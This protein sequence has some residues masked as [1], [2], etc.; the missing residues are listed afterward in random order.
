[1]T[2]N[3]DVDP[4][5]GTDFSP[6]RL[7]E[8]EQLRAEIWKLAATAEAA[9]D[10]TGL[11]QNLLNQTGPVLGCE[12]ISF[13][14]RA[15]TQTEFM[16]KLQWRADGQNTGLG[17][18]VPAS[19]F[20]QSLGQPYRQLLFDKGLVSANPVLERFEKEYGPRSVLIVPYGTPQQPEGYITVN[21]FTCAKEYSP[22]EIDLFIELSKIIHL[23]SKQ[24]QTQTA[25]RESETRY[26]QIFETNQAIKLLIDPAD[27]RIVAAN[28][29]AARFYGYDIPALTQMR[30]MDINVMSP[31]QVQQE[32]DRACNTERLFFE[33]RHRLASGE[34]R[35]V[36]VYSGPVKNPPHDLLYSIVHDVTE[37][38]Q[39]EAALYAQR[40]R[41]D[42][43]L[44]GANLGMWDWN[45][46]T[47]EVVFNARWA[48]MLGYTLA[49]IEPNVSSWEKLLHPDDKPGVMTVLTDHLAGRT[50]VYQTEHRLRA[51][52]GEWI[53]VLDSGMVLARDNQG[54]PLRAAGIHQDIT[55]RKEAEWLLQLQRN[56]TLTL[57]ATSN[58]VEA[59][60]Q[61]LA[62]AFQIEGI[63]CGGGYLIDERTGG[64]TLVAHQ[65][66][67]PQFIKNTAYYPADA[68]QTR[69]V[70]AGWPLYTQYNTIT[71][72]N[73]DPNTENLRALAVIPVLHDDQVIAALNLASHTHDVIS[74]NARAAIEVIASQIGGVI[75]RIRAEA[76]QQ[77]TRQNLQT[78]F[79]TV[80]DFLFVLDAKGN[81]IK[82]N[83]VVQQ[84]L[85]YS[86]KELTKMQVLEVHPPNR[87]A[88]AEAIIVAML[89]GEQTVCPIPLITK[90]GQL[91]P[92]ETKVVLGQWNGQPSLF[93]LSRDITER[94]QSEQVLH[95]S[96]RQLEAALAELRETQ[97]KMIQ[98]ERLAAVGQLA[99]GI[100]H[101]FNNILTSILGFTELLQLS[102]GTPPSIQARLQKINASSKRA[103]HLVRQITDFSRKTIIQPQQIDL[104]AF[105]TDSIRF[106]ETTLPENIQINFSLE[107]GPDQYLVKADPTQLQEIITNLAINA[108]NA[109]PNGGKLHFNL[110]WVK[111]DGTLH[112]AVCNQ[113]IT[114]EWLQLTVTDTGSGITANI[115]P[116]IFEPFFTTR[117]LG[118]GTG[119]GL[120]QVV[121]IV[122]QH[123]GHTRVDSR[124][125]YG[126][127]F[128]IY[129]PPLL[130]AEE[131]AELRQLRRGHGEIIL[132][133]EDEP[134]VLE[135]TTAMLESL[136]Y[137]V[138]PAP[139][140]EKAI[141][142][143]D[144]F[145]DKIALVLSDM[146][147]PDID[148]E[149]LFE[150]FKAKNPRLKMVMM[151]GYP[152]EE[153]GARLLEQGVLGW[154]QKPM[155]I[156]QLAQT[157]SAALSTE[158][159]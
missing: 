31:A 143:F 144:N 72:N 114:G 56:L 27:G 58:I 13:M 158:T 28:Q 122:E 46:P 3:Q 130:P 8:L 37:R 108:K 155:S 131:I 116:R 57:S 140:G 92:V 101:H 70:M 48:E 126:T 105:T 40:E 14:L 136:D 149:K 109:M 15:E 50:S 132:V 74:V 68:P 85:G 35:E 159:K 120:S 66:L 95:H 156:G 152:P 77:E 147:M 138:F 53:W 52:S 135:I 90:T 36:E 91:I 30:I 24:L 111:C 82:T 146:M 2:Q 43:V 106:L 59:F 38:H 115:L 16:V 22:A 1:M 118:E 117:E 67:P 39:A 33:F 96:H 148:G 25:L 75:A 4:S 21:N 127:T 80:N 47:G 93:G 19:I 60:Q 64:L 139:T 128:T 137:R 157:V 86:A 141:A 94:Q 134:S 104:I 110:A 29:A 150:R 6:S 41:L 103:A 99:A 71:D 84:R 49:E 153:R 142:L 62:A 45:I 83:P 78:L 124:V 76:A 112:C 151:S 121:G 65:G 12:N 79:D 54:N 42:L 100:A 44:K 125:G 113:P 154:C 145:R 5:K 18:V 89:A 88:E 123:R 87:R 69:L 20:E 55:Q 51:K 7:V 98:Q 23:K 63:D 107:A 9:E 119:L 11:I 129:L 61:V 34:I 26:R 97:E 17:E 73:D 10:E 102:P 81:I 133:I 32:M